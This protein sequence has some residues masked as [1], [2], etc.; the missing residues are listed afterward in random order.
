V[1]DHLLSM[2]SSPSA[3]L[4]VARDCAVS[5]RIVFGLIEAVEIA[6]VPRA[7][8]LRAAGLEAGLLEAADARVPRSEVFRLCVL[9]M[10]LT[11][12]PA[13]GLHWGERFTANTLAPISQ[14]IA[15]AATLRQSFESLQQFQRLVTDEPSH[16]VVESKDRVIVRCVSLPAEPLRVQRFAAEMF[17]TGIFKLIRSFSVRARPERVSFNHAAPSYHSEY[18]RLFE[19]VE[20]FEQPYTGIEFDRALMSAASLHKDDDLHGALRSIAERRVLRLM[21]RTPYAVRVHEHIVR[22]GPGCDTAMDS[23]ASALGLSVR[24]L[25]RRLAAEGKTYDS[26]ANEALSM[27]AKHLLRDKQ[28][29]VQEVAYEMGFSDTCTFHRAFKR[30]TGTTPRAY[31]DETVTERTPRTNAVPPARASQTHSR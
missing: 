20:H 21:Q 25:R 10:D 4:G 15:H 3:Q 30:W 7:E 24:S 9:A 23:V 2:T 14:L 31:R 17:V 16:E 18:T 27:I 29:T 13:L 26:I 8:F 12:D 6:G 22:Q 5:T 11:A 28:Q 19:G 1:T